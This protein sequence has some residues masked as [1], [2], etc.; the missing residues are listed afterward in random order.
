[1][2]KG[3]TETTIGNVTER[4]T[5]GSHY[6]PKTVDQGFPYVTVRDL[7]EGKINFATSARIDKESFEKLRKNGC[8]PNIGDVL[9]SKDG[10]VGKVAL[11]REQLDFV[12]LSSL[13]I[14]SPD[15]RKVSSEFL[16]IILGSPDFQAEAIGSKTG[17]AIKRV[18]LKT[19][20]HLS[21][22]L[23]PL[24]EQK[25][26]VDLITAVDIVCSLSLANLENLKRLKSSLESEVFDSEDISP[27]PLGTFCDKSDIQIG[28]FGSQLHSH[29]YT[30]NGVPVVMPKNLVENAISDE[31][32]ARISQEKADEL[33]RH[34]LR[35]GDV[36]FARRGDL[37]KR[38]L[39]GQREEGW[40]CG[41][42]TVRVRSEKLHGLILFYA[43]KTRSVNAWLLSN[44]VGATMPNLNTG[45]VAEIPFR[46]P[47][48][49]E[50]IMEILKALEESIFEEGNRA[51]RINRL[52]QS[53]LVDLLAGKHEIPASYDSVMGAA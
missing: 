7:S 32:I 30:K 42:G 44:A 46:I 52:R 10:T 27:Q 35:V 25:R 16:A 15:R 14:L 9:F 51:R 39:V 43:S 26:I 45:L 2:R 31:G 4:L 8:A 53:I 23:P 33:E 12:V 29:E 18:V 28:P 41:T 22:N 47:D 40:I 6:S 48:N 11:V 34:K 21:L 38:A 36:L 5:D 19:L 20:K 37:T 17:L 13:A 3:W 1:M 49:P 50:E 24:H